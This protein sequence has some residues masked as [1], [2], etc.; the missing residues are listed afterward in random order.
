M[1]AAPVLAVS[2]E[3]YREGPMPGVTGGFGEPTCRMCHFD[4]GLNEPGGTLQVEG[5]PPAY[6]PG[7][8][9]PITVVLR[10]PDV[11]RGGFEMA[12]RFESPPDA[13]RQAGHLRSPDARTQ[14]VYGKDSPVQ[15]I[16]HTDRGST[17]SPGE[18]RWTVYWT[19]PDGGSGPVMFHIAANASNDD[20]SALGDFIY[21]TSATSR[22]R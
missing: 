1:V 5:V 20:A 14:I 8:E 15:Y 7:E 16:Q 22:R 10:R 12:A 11:V 4:R 13:G 9:Y 19:A 2:L 21:M 18:G 6:V 17:T 3:S